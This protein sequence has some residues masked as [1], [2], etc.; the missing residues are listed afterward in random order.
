MEQLPAA[1]G[2]GSISGQLIKDRTADGTDAQL[3]N[4]LEASLAGAS[5]TTK[6]A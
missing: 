3:V 2:M 4:M 6:E 5:A 1:R